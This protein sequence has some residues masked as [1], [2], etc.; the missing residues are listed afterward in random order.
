[1]ALQQFQRGEIN[2]VRLEFA[3]NANGVLVADA[4][5]N[6]STQP[7]ST[8]GFTGVAGNVITAILRKG[9]IITGV[10]GFV[11]T[12][13]NGTAAV[14]I[15][16]SDGTTTFINA[17]SVTSASATTPITAAVTTKDFPTG[18]TLTAT[19]TDGT[20]TAST[21][22]WVVLLISYEDDRVVDVYDAG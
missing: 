5:A 13:F 3:V 15:T 11:R 8:A 22:G 14:T 6:S 2:T 1:M 21:A 4:N 16:L 17:Q 9:A 20:T 7:L 18:G 12:A 19:L 10:T